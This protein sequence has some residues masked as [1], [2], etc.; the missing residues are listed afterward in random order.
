MGSKCKYRHHGQGDRFF[1]RG[2]GGVPASEPVNEPTRVPASMLASVSERVCERACE[3]ACEPPSGPASESANEPAS[4]SAR[5]TGRGRALRYKG[6]GDPSRGRAYSSRM[7]HAIDYK[8]VLHCGIHPDW[9][10][11]S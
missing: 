8:R 7:W 3:R 11:D 6:A 9:R 5:A 4:E 2:R 1:G 10:P